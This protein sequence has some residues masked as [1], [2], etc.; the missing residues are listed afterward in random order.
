MNM[1]IEEVIEK[2]STLLQ[3]KNKDYGDDNLKEYGI[4]G[5]MIRISDKLARIKVALNTGNK[6]VIEDALIDIAGYSINGI[7]LLDEPDGIY[8]KF[9]DETIDISEVEED[10]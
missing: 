1:R 8:G 5:L 2:V 6:K 7:R 4:L 10:D 9:W 3:Q